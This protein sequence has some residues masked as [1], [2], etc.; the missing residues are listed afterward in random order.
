MVGSH[1]N[2]KAEPRFDFDHEVGQSRRR[3]PEESL[4]S[5]AGGRRRDRATPDFR[6]WPAF[7]KPNAELNA[8][9]SF[10]LRRFG[11]MRVS[12]DE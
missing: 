4:P 1:P 10:C 8:G 6:F 3:L 5:Q 2:G 7:L 12:V 9:I 11:K